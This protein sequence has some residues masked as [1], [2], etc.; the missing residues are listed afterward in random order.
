M[1][2]T[3]PVDISSDM[4][5]SANLEEGAQEKLKGSSSTTS[6]PHKRA[7]L[8]RTEGGQIAGSPLW[9]KKPDITGMTIALGSSYNPQFMN[10]LCFWY[11][12]WL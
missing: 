4:A 6:A 2:V 7:C 8:A 11:N 10:I 3:T 1:S 9:V 12:L 5:P